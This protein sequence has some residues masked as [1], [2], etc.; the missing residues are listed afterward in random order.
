MKKLEE[1]LNSIPVPKKEL[2]LGMEDF[3]NSDEVFK[4]LETLKKNPLNATQSY[5]NSKNEKLD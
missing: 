4:T 1:M 5:I 2:G 3:L